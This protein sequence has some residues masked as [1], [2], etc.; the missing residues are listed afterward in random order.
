MP[1]EKEEMI[2][3]P[4]QQH[5]NKGK[6]DRNPQDKEPELEIVVFNQRDEVDLV[7]ECAKKFAD[8]LKRDENM[9]TQLRKFYQEYV[10]IRQH[11]KYSNDKEKDLVRIKMLIAKAAY[12][13]GRKNSKVPLDFLKWFTANLSAIG[14]D[15]SQLEKDVE[16]F[17]N[18]F[19][20]FIGYF[21]AAGAK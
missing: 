21:Y 6:S 7:E 16:K 3:M 20:A 5:N 19:E 4:G 2:K 18:Y 12:A 1:Q 10:D 9:R 8:A 11:I 13:T 15:K 17:G 14:K